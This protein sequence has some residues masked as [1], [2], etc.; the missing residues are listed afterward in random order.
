[1]SAMLELKL[2]P[3]AHRD[4]GGVLYNTPSPPRGGEGG[5]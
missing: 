1:M 5:A 3:R 4:L 2:R